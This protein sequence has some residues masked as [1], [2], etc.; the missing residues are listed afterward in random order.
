MALADYNLRYELPFKDVDGNQWRVRIY[1]RDEAG[2]VERL[3]GTGNPV[4]IYYEGDE[5]LSSGII[6]SSCTIRVYG[7]PDTAGTSDL[8]QFFVSDEERFYVKVEYAPDGSTYSTYWTGFLFQDE[9]T[10]YITSDPYEVELI[11]L[12][13]LG[14]I[15]D[16]MNDLG[17]SPSENPTLISIV[18]SFV[19]K[20]KLELTITEETGIS[21]ENGNVTSFL[22]DQTVSAQ[23]FL[24]E[25]EFVEMVSVNEVVSSLA[26]SLNCRVW[27]QEGKLYFSSMFSRWSESLD[28]SVPSDVIS[29]ENG[30]S[31]RHRSSKKITNISI[32]IGSKNI[33]SNPS[34]ELD[35]IDDTTPTGWSK[36]AANTSAT[37][38]V[39]NTTVAEGST[40]SLETIN[41]RI[42]DSTFNDASTSNKN[43]LYCLLETNTE[44]ISLDST[45]IADKLQCVLE[46]SYF[47]DN[48]LTSEPY[49]LRFSMSRDNSAGTELFYN[50][51]TGV[52]STDFAYSFFDAESSGKWDNL[53]LNFY[54]N[55]SFFGTSN[56]PITLRLHTMNYSDEGLSDV[57]VYYDNFSIRLY[58]FNG[59]GSTFLYPFTV[60]DKYLNISS[61]QDTDVKTDSTSI[62]LMM[63]VTN[64]A[65]GLETIRTSSNGIE[66]LKGKILGQYVNSSTTIPEDVFFKDDATDTFSP[67]PSE[68]LRLRVKLDE[69]SRKVYSGTF[70][71]KRVDDSSWT[72]IFFGDKFTIAY[73]GY[74]DAKINTFTRFGFEIKENRYN[75]DAINL[76]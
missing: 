70:A 40:Q 14:T 9:Y 68:L 48:T 16:S 43:G 45:G 31:A 29:V 26:L 53:N 6:G 63:G 27:Q 51:E 41:N 62:E 36:P 38:S 54:L 21:A 20:T 8:S 19:D 69:D 2:S 72:P 59:G 61:D 7:R 5:D 39:S 30:L 11:A 17:Y 49:E 52:W 18:Q 73:T 66:I 23:T 58:N 50:W 74:S 3:W 64:V 37:I 55:A 56:T 34:F 22:T 42:S 76:P 10:E 32:Q 71:T 57:V 25:D 13:R 67:L 28:F 12:D 60:S 35:A 33:L 47:I 15:K 46:F 44:N 4:S 1:D 65:T 75:I 24:L